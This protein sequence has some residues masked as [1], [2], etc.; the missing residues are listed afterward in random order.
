M[1]ENIRGIGVQAL[2]R[3][4]LNQLK[5]G[6]FSEK[7]IERELRIDNCK[8]RSNKD[9]VYQSTINS[10]LIWIQKKGIV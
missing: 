2:S 10:N 6:E 4:F 3:Q 1:D 7:D 5:E 8:V 9:I